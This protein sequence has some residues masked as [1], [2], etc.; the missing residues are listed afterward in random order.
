MPSFL[1][2]KSIEVPINRYKCLLK[3]CDVVEGLLE[4]DVWEVIFVMAV[5]TL[6]S[7]TVMIPS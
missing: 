7:P 5:P 4:G 6:T 1:C 3:C 2:V